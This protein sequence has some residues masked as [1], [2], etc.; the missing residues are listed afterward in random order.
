MNQCPI[1]VEPAAGA[2]P[3]LAPGPGRRGF[4]LIELLVVIAIIAILAAMLLP[5]LSAAKIKAQ[6][7]ACLSN[8][9]QLIFA[10]MIY[11]DDNNGRLAVNANNVAQAAGTVGWVDDI[12]SWDFPPAPAST[13][14]TNTLLLANAL[15]GPYCSR[16]VG[17]Y[18]C[19]GDNYESAKGSR[20][21]SYSMNSQMGGGIV[22]L[23]SGQGDVVNQWGGAEN[24]RIFNKQ[25]DII[26]PSPVNAWVFV[27]EHPDSINDGLFR[28]NMD[29]SDTTP[30]GAGTWNDYPANNHGGSGALA[31]GDG[32]AETHKWTDPSLVPNPVKHVKNNSMTATAPFTDLIWLQQRTT[33]LPN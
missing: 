1:N 4:T 24:W 5:A 11:A 28:V 26:A 29:N 19:P 20:V 12:M 3:G 23:T 10:W 21:R 27:D 33:S 13:D 16:A 22:A 30:G 17:I 8:Q 25:S 2:I 6:R 32:H 18:K 9:R 15:L 14:N 7:I 31:F